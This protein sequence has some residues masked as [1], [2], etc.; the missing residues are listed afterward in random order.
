ME[1]D[2]EGV[3]KVEA[4]EVNHIFSPLARGVGARRYVCAAEDY[5]IA[6]GLIELGV[7]VEYRQSAILA[8]AQKL[9]FDSEREQAAGAVLVVEGRGEQQHLG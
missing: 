3:S 7:D 4:F 5:L 1:T 9:A 6:L 2:E 8:V